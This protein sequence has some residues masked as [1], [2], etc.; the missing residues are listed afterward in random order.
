[1]PI[2]TIVFTM[3]IITNNSIYNGY[4]KHCCFGKP[5]RRTNYYWICKQAAL[6]PLTDMFL[7]ETE[8][9][10]EMGGCPRQ[11]E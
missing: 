2:L 3:I 9:C 6:T 10:G 8:H 11:I 4:F 5:S 1:M 7:T